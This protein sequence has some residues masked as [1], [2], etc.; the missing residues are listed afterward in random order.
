M[1][2]RGREMTVNGTERPSV[3]GTSTPAVEGNG[4]DKTET[5]FIRKVRRFKKNYGRIEEP[6]ENR[7]RKVAE[8]LG[9]SALR[10]EE[11]IEQVEEEFEAGM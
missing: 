2:W 1:K 8:E 11:L 6:E 7:L 9:I 5:L 4:H 3:R 10:R